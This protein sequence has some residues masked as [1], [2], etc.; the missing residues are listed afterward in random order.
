ML[1]HPYEGLDED[2]KKR[3]EMLEHIF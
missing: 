3:I 2:S 1:I